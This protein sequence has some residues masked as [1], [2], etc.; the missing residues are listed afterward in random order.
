[1]AEIRIESKSVPWTN[2]YEHSYLVYVNDAGAEFVIRGGPESDVPGLWGAIVVEA[3]VSIANSEDARPVE[4]R[5]LRGSIVLEL[6]GRNATAVWD[7]MLQATAT[8]G[9]AQFT[10]D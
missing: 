2:G 7:S 1:V 6:N 3:G 8:I 10:Y 9:S 4:D 5:A